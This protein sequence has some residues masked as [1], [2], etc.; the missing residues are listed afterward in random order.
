[1]NKKQLDKL[2][3]LVGQG[4]NDAFSL[5]YNE[6][7]K[8]VYAFLYSYYNDK[9][10]TEDG[11]QSVFLKIKLNAHMY[12]AGSN[13]MAW[14]LQIAKNQALNDIKKFG[15]SIADDEVGLTTAVPP[16]DSR[17]EV[18]EAI[19]KALK[20]DERQIVI[21]HTL[22][23]YKHKEIGE[24]LGVPTGTVTSKYKTSISKLKQFLQKGG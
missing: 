24:L 17:A 16:R 20:S 4:D 14:I 22:W 23:G 3:V 18:F 10:N 11:L 15:R 9:F 8:G 7:A 21:L 12:K 6:T 19:N 1:M 2:L 5:L 13:A